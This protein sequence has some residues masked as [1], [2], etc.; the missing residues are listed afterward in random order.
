M[1]L[2]IFN[3]K[4]YKNSFSFFF[5][6]FQEH[7]FNF[8]PLFVIKNCGLTHIS[9]FNVAGR[10]EPQS[11]FDKVSTYKVGFYDFLLFIIRSRYQSIFQVFDYSTINLLFNHQRSVKLTETHIVYLIILGCFVCRQSLQVAFYDKFCVFKNYFVTKL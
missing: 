9:K 7:L 4:N 6:F 5:F 2:K 8:F 3:K 10:L 1:K 11:I